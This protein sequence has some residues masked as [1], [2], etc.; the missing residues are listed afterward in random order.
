[1]KCVIMNEAEFL[2]KCSDIGEGLEVSKYTKVH[3]EVKNSNF[4]SIVVVPT[5]ELKQRGDL[6]SKVNRIEALTYL[7]RT[8]ILGFIDGEVEHWWSYGGEC[9]LDLLLN[10]LLNMFIETE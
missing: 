4:H 3:R 5:K 2:K 6:P 1:M 8:Y 10:I 9:T 7:S